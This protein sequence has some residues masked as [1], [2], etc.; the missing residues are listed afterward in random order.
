MKGSELAGQ[1]KQVQRKILGLYSADPSQHTLLE[2]GQGLLTGAMVAALGFYFLNKVGLLTG[3][4]AG[5]AFL[6]HYALG[7]S[8][9][10]LFFIV[11]LPFYY[12]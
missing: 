8:F 7:I 6:L 4:T 11:N 5:V 10:L 12:I 9:G 2:D 1:Q 3:G